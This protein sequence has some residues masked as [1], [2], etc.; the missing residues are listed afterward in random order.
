M[1]A[2]NNFND[3]NGSLEALPLSP[4]T[5]GSLGFDNQFLISDIDNSVSLDEKPVV[6]PEGSKEKD[7]E[8]KVGAKGGFKHTEE[9][10]E[11][12]KEGEEEEKEEKEETK[13][14]EEEEKKEDQE[15]E[16]I[17][18]KAEEKLEDV[19]E[20]EEK[21]IKLE[22]RIEEEEAIEN[23]GQLTE[24]T[25]KLTED[26]QEEEAMAMVVPAKAMS[27]EPGL[28]ASDVPNHVFKPDAP[29]YVQTRSLSAASLALKK[30][31]A[32][33]EAAAATKALAVEIPKTD[34]I[35][36]RIK[37]FGGAANPNRLGGFRKCSVKEMVRKFKNVEEQN[38]DTIA[39]VVR[40]HND[41]EAQGACSAYSLLT[42]SRSLRPT[43][44]RKMSHELAENGNKE[45]VRSVIHHD[46]DHK[47]VSQESVHSVRNAKS[48]FESLAK[49][50]GAQALNI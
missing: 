43:P 47:G 33:E 7:Q 14:E 5:D 49:R 38:Q 31:Q 48:I 12:E 30:K 24:K 45:I 6:A 8:G 29:T 34:S 42:A 32:A 1:S 10:E 13:E 21:E 11:K 37:L 41:A 19:E 15:S 17:E 9:Q 35:A 44:R 2:N 20:E 18:E 26:P 36:E 40:G 4:S 16:E 3:I 22:E 23:V 39:H 25:A 50:G 27:N 46:D 28:I